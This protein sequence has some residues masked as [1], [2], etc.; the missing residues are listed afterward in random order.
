MKQLSRYF[1]LAALLPLTLACSENSNNFSTD[2]N[3]LNDELGKSTG[4][5][6]VIIESSDLGAVASEVG[7]NGGE[8][9]KNLEFISALVANVPEQALNGLKKK[10]PDAVISEDKVL[11]LVSPVLEINAKANSAP[12]VQP[13]QSIP[14][15]I[16]NV[17]ADLAWST[18]KG[19]GVIVCVVDTGIDKTHPDLVANIIGGKNFV[20]SGRT[21]NPDNWNDD[22]GHGSHVAG[23]IAAVDNAI[24]VVGVAPMAKLYG[25]KVLNKQGSG[26]TSDIADGVY[27]CVAAGAKVINMSLGGAG[28]P[29]APSVF[30][31][32]INSA[33]SKGVFVVAAAGN[34]GKD[35]AGYTPAGYNGVIAVSAVD[36]SYNFASWTNFGLK[37]DDFAAPGVSV[38]STWKGGSYNTISGTSMAAPHVAGVIALGIAAN[39][40]G[41]KGRDLGA[42]MSLQGGGFIDALLTL[43]NL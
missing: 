5:S 3:A 33:I 42:V 25:A 15:G 6:R 2:A 43:S 26:Y 21:L 27:A 41:P 20:G 35:I 39:S 30:K 24:G 4:P 18:S 37:A 16:K 11:S 14:Y 36:S 38:L 28:D 32:A 19:A 29:N 1:L 17:K 40:K 13:P 8:V 7:K 23:T 9:V 34:S 31:D 22:N 12:I 10:F